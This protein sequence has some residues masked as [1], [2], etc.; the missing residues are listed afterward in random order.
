MKTKVRYIGDK[1]CWGF[2][3]NFIYDVTDIDE[4][5]GNILPYWIV[6]NSGI[7]ASG[8]AFMKEDAVIVSIIPDELFEI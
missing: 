3:Q 4:L 8:M 5:S 6:L 7:R 2:V 1:N